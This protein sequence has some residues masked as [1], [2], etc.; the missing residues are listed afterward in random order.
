MAEE[1]E[2]QE[3]KRTALNN[4]GEIITWS[5]TALNASEVAIE[6][7]KHYGIA[8]LVHSIECARAIRH[9][10]QRELHG[11]QPPLPGPNMRGR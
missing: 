3:W 8:L 7:P 2:W 9:C 1:R 6:G 10:T 5:S 11:P 4:L